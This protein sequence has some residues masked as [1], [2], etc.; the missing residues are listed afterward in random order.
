LCLCCRHSHININNSL[1][2]RITSL[3][4]G[5]D[6]QSVHRTR[7]LCLTVRDVEIRFTPHMIER[8]FWFIGPEFCGP[9]SSGSHMSTAKIGPIISHNLE[10]VQ[11]RME[12]TSIIIID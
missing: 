8:C 11:D 4:R 6:G 2:L 7:E 9:K 12:M 3:G 5:S 10:M 1:S